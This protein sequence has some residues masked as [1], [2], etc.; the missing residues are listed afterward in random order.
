MFALKDNLDGNDIKLISNLIEQYIDFDVN[1]LILQKDKIK[2]SFNSEFFNSQGFDFVIN[3]IAIKQKN[4][5]KFPTL[6][7]K[8][9][10]LF[11]SNI[12]AEQSSSEL[13][14]KYKSE[15]IEKYDRSVD[16]TDRKS[17]V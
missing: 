5:K 3:Q 14:A 13:T 1:K 12:S 11:P 6:I 4:V 15:I 9:D 10:F 2:V 16:L 7:S 8:H 17:V